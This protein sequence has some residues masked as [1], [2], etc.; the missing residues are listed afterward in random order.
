VKQVVVFDTNVLISGY[1]WKRKPRQALMLIKSSDFSLLICKESMDE[2]VRV[3]SKKFRLNAREI[4]RI[5]LDIETISRNI[6]VS[7]SERPINDDPSDNLFINLAI[8]GNAKLIV[9]GDSHLLKLKRYS[10]IE[11]IAVD[12]FV[13]RYS[14]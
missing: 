4:Y 14:K 2:L 11:I 6:N 7:S 10:G 12:E 3:L 8:D 1:L 13:K 9:S 5:V